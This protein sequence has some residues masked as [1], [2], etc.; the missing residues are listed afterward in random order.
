MIEV[1]VVELRA[2]D[3]ARAIAAWRESHKQAPGV[4]RVPWAYYK[5]KYGAAF[6]A[7]LD[8]PSGVNLGAYVATPDGTGELVGFL[9][10]TRGRSVDTLHWVGTF[11]KDATGA[12]LRRR[13]IM[14]KLLAAAD[15]GPRFVYTLRGRRERGHRTLDVALAQTLAERGQAAGY[16][17]LL[18]WLR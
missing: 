3:R 11:Y 13:G 6:R 9:V 1:E 18:E 5:E 8:D 10:G 12:P 4:D 14:T 2:G 17:P 15:F 7:L 16:V